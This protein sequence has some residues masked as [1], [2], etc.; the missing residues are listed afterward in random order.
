MLP[1][2]DYI[3]AWLNPIVE[4][5]KRTLPDDIEFDFRKHVLPLFLPFLAW[6]GELRDKAV[7]KADLMAGFVGA[8]IVLPQG[9]AF[10]MIAGLPPAFGLYTAI[11]SASVA[12]IFGSSYHM[13]SGPNT[14]L[15]IMVFA[16][17]GKMASVGSI[18]YIDAV[19][20]LTFLT[21]AFQFAMGIWNMGKYVTF[22][23]HTVIVGFTS[24][25]AVLI[26]TNQ[27]GNA[28]GIKIPSSSS[29]LETITTILTHLSMVKLPVL[30]VSVYTL[31]TAVVVRRVLPKLPFLIVGLV[32]G[33]TLA[34]LINGPNLGIPYV[35]K[36]PQ[37]LPTLSLPGFTLG[38]VHGLLSSAFAVAVLGLIQSVAIAKSLSAQ[39]GQPINNNQEFFGQGL[40]NIVGSFFS[41][42]P[43]SGSFTRSGLNYQAGAKTPMSVIFAAL[44]LFTI[45]LLFSPLAQYLPL[46][47]VSG[48]IL[49][50]GWGLFDG[51]EIR[52]IRHASKQDN[53]IF[54]ATFFTTLFAELQFAIYVGVLL[55][56]FFY[57]IKTSKPNVAVMVPDGSTARHEFVNFIR[58][59]VVPQ[60]PQIKII[61]IDGNL[62]F[63]AIDYVSSIVREMGKGP[64]KHLLILANGINFV[65]LDGAEWLAR[66]AAFW[67]KKGGGLYF[68]RLKIIAQDVMKAGGFLDEIG[69]D[70]FFTTKTD[71]IA[72]IYKK[73]D[74]KTCK[75][76]P[77][78]V[79]L[80][81]AN[82]KRLPLIEMPKPAKK[83]KIA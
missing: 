54:W 79:F 32:F 44:I 29:F 30:A 69:Q 12:A 2:R 76:C 47:A 83:Q 70:H 34:L 60:C 39:S 81:C 49:L 53:I 75:N 40:S 63:G 7:L 56:L 48:L 9:I 28:L 8:F 67:R 50:I 51:K 37:A 5:V 22:V 36:I 17:V 80:E 46:P 77:Y 72:S 71:A 31:V 74:R 78:R 11:V 25:A 64:E 55:S 41:C 35:A 66:E 6:K 16:V 73:L 24:G 52:E 21:G 4:E 68:V 1:V 19:L 59:P 26:I 14:P 20:L 65:D 58:K 42:Y 61:R 10:A 82:D 23:S 38:N 27:L 18:D 3:K 45:M 57:L 15:S 13:V 33:S 62:Y 43:S